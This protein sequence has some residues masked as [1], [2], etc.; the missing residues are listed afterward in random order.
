MNKTIGIDEIQERFNQVVEEVATSHV[1]YV[2]TRDARPSIVMISYEDYLK[3]L[4]RQE[5]I[6]RFNKTWAEIGEKN[7][8]YSEQ[9]VAADLELATKELRERRKS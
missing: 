8:Q 6:A 1:P 7:A 5:I 4:S 3:L 9:E 2:L